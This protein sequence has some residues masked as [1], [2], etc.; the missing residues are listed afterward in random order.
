MIVVRE[1]K[2]KTEVKGFAIALRLTDYSPS[3]AIAQ[4]YYESRI[5]L[6]ACCK[7]VGEW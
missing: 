1:Q 2:N 4:P 6:P 7:S 5:V 3:R